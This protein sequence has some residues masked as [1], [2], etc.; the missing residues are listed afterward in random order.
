VKQKA[1]TMYTAVLILTWS[2]LQ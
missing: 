1:A 2:W